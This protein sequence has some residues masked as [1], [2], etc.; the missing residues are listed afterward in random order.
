MAA[1]E[2][3]LAA[4]RAK[5]EE[6]Y[7]GLEADRRQRRLGNRVKNFVKEHWKAGTAL[8]AGLGLGYLALKD[9]NQQNYPRY[10]EQ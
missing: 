5:R 3:E 2:A 7:A 1:Q 6:F 8:G 10:S 9:R 4:K